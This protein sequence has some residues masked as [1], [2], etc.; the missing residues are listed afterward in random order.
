MFTQRWPIA[1]LGDCNSQLWMVYLGCVPVIMAIVSVGQYLETRHRRAIVE[2]ASHGGDVSAD[3]ASIVNET[4]LSAF[5]RQC[6]SGSQLY[7]RIP[8]RPGFHRGPR[9]AAQ[10]CSCVCENPKE[11]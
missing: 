1:E 8:V 5:F 6:F 2:S 11:G 9:W 10:N 3:D 4:L 7:D